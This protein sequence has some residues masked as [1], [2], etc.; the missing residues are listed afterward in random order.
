MIKEPLLLC[1]M[2][3]AA[4]ACDMAVLWAMHSMFRQQKNMLVRVRSPIIALLQG[5]MYKMYI[6]L[7]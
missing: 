5:S 7:K 3:A 2:L 6:Q 1:K 4:V